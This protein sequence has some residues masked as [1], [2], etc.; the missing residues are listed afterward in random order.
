[1]D[2]NQPGTDVEAVSQGYV[3]ITPV[4]LDWTDHNYAKDLRDQLRNPIVA[5]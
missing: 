4:S 3:S 2:P 5:R 1:M